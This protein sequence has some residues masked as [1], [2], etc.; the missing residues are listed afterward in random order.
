MSR[1]IQI[2]KWVRE[3]GCPWDEHTC[4]EAASKGDLE[5]LKWAREHGCPCTEKAIMYAIKNNQVETLNYLA[6]ADPCKP[7]TIFRLATEEGK[8]HVL[9]WAV[10]KFPEYDHRNFRMLFNSD[11]PVKFQPQ[12][13]TWLY[14]KGIISPEDCSKT[15]ETTP[16]VLFWMIKHKISPE[17]LGIWREFEE[18][19]AFIGYENKEML[20]GAWEVFREPQL[21]GEF[22]EKMMEAGGW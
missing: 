7:E 21:V 5:K 14:K 4:T 16:S 15:L 13:L 3:H 9:N 10:K 11:H 22:L 2:L 12:V 1:N 18:A 17:F 8:I 20:S 6:N 19:V